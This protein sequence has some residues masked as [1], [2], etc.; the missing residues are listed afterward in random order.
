MYLN[1]RQGQE[2][3]PRFETCARKRR[4]LAKTCLEDGGNDL[5]PRVH[6]PSIR[7]VTI[8]GMY[9]SYFLALFYFLS[10]VDDNTFKLIDRMS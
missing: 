4:R 9:T 8:N 1:T 10:L 2:N 7:V 3:W 6:V 5:G